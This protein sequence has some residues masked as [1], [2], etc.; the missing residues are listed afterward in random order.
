MLVIDPTTGKRLGLFMIS[1]YAP[2]SDASA[3]DQ[4]LFENVLSSAISRR[5]LGDI[6]VICADA[7]SSLGRSAP[8]RNDVDIYTTIGPYGIN[9]IN[10]SGSRLRS[11]LE[12]HNLASLS[13]FFKK[14]HYG[15]WQHPRSKL[16]NH[17]HYFFFLST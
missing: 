7:T 12:I 4:L 3:N 6:L 13:S 1:A 9:H 14:R 5:N 15:T 2:S 11:F 17:L 8:K 10:L 16:Q